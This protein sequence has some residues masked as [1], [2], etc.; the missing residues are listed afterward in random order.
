MKPPFRA[1]QVGSLLRPEGLR[2]ARA[3]FKAG[4]LP[5]DE[6]RKAE[7]DA[8]REAVTKQESIG[9]QGITDGEFRRDWWH[10]DFMAGL[11][12]VTMRTN[13]GPQFKDTEEQPP[14][15]TVTDKVGYGDPIMIEDF[16]FLASTTTRT[17]KFTIPSPA[18]LHLRGGRKAISTEAYPDLEE[19]WDDVAGAYRDAIR[20]FADAG[21]TY[22][23]LDDVSWAYLCDDG[24]REACRA[25][26]DDPDALPATYARVINEAVRDRPEGMTITMHTCRGNFKSTFVASGGYDRVA[27]AMFSTDLDGYFMEFDSERAGTF[28]PLRYL[29]DGKKVV[30]GLVTTKFGELEDKGSIERRIEAAARHVPM[31]NLCVSPQCGFSSTHHGNQLSQDDQW[32]KLERIVEIADEVWP[33]WH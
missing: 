21:C 31:D 9:L 1:D 26:G 17:A 30:L 33:G 29:Q 8:I 27:E 15:A 22:L 16:E 28:E 3:K 2:Q 19:F 12:G 24:V 25:N 32:H 13:R 7:D 23:Q 18:M 6:L 5:A 4:E 14:V 10:L 20:A 11:D